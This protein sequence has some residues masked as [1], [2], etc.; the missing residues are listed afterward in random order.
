MLCVMRVVEYMKLKFKKPMKLCIDN[1]G[2]AELVNNWP[3][4]DRTR[5]CEI[6]DHFF[7]RVK[8]KKY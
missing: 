6:K 1:K 7:K 8:R 4:G 3:V 2:D 5:H